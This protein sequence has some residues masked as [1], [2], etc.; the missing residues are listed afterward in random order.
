[1]LARRD[2]SLLMG[3]SLRRY[4]LRNDP[5]KLRMVSHQVSPIKYNTSSFQFLFINA[6]TL[7]T[8]AG[9]VRNQNKRKS[10]DAIPVENF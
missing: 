6:R 5:N 3:L 4:R 8:F 10:I 7:T 9:P 1:M 2:T